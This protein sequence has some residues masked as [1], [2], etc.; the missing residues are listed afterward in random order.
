MIRL[1]R[2]LVLGLVA[3]GLCAGSVPVVLH[4]GS[5]WASRPSAR[6]SRFTPADAMRLRPGQYRWAA[7]AGDES[8]MRVVV[9]LTNQRAFAFQGDALVGIAAI[10][11]GRRGHGTPTGNFPILQKARYHRSNIY[12]DAPMPYMQRLTWGGIALHAGYNPGRPASHGCIR[13]P[14][15]FARALFAATRVGSMVMVTRGTPLVAP[16][17]QVEASPVEMVSAAPEQRVAPFR[18]INIMST[19]RT[20][21]YVV[22]TM[23]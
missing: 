19:G 22:A 13:L 12:S 16:P 10:S 2:P 4:E 3:L 21:A 6:H 15:G 1:R 8:P 18:Q 5:Y 7:Y 11:T 23:L 9:D 20:V 17:E 14:T